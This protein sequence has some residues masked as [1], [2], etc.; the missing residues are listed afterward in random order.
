MFCSGGK[1]GRSITNARTGF[2]VILACSFGTKP[3]NAGSRQAA[4]GSHATNLCA[5]IDPVLITTRNR[6]R[7]HGSQWDHLFADGESFRLGEIEARV[8]FSP[9]HTLASITYVFGGPAFIHDTLFIPD[10]GTARADF[11]GAMRMR[12]GAV[13]RTFSL[14]RDNT[15]LYTRH[16]ISPAA[17][18]PPGRAPWPSKRWRTPISAAR[19]RQALSSCGPSA[20]QPC[21]CPS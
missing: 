18:R 1:D 3:K 19:T 17:V 13:S 12:C 9:G 16:T 8:M 7:Q 20:M 21:Q 14:C 5:I 11:P 10:S 2:I 15:R 6:V 4:R